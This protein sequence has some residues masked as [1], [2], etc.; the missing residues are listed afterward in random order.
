MA[1]D[2]G[3]LIFAGHF[4]VAGLAKAWRPD[5]PLAVLL[6]ATQLP[7]LLVHRPDMPFLPG[8]IGALPLLGSGLWEAPTVAALVEGLLVL[9]GAGAYAWRTLREEPRRARAWGHSAGVAILLVGSF[10]FDLL[11]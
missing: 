4:G 3:D 5:I 9:A 8:D 11:G 6:V 7:D 2:G 1:A 10:A